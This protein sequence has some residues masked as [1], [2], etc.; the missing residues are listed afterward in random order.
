M[1]RPDVQTVTA[2]SPAAR[3]SPAGTTTPTKT[4]KTTPNAARSTAAAASSAPESYMDKMVRE[5]MEFKLAN[6]GGRRR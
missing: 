1:G 6:L 4:A 2:P 3:P 5:A